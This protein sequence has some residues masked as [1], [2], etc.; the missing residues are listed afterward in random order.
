MNNTWSIT[1][2]ET[3]TKSYDIKQNDLPK[4]ELKWLKRAADFE[5]D[6]ADEEYIEIFKKY[7]KQVKDGTY[8]S[9]ES[10]LFIYPNIIHDRVSS[11]E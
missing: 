1:V 4:N 7:G 2:K 10:E 11:D 5:I 3:I 6:L 8:D 9:C